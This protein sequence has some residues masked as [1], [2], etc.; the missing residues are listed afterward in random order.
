MNEE[1]S[2]GWHSKD[3][4]RAAALV[5]A[6]Y[7]AV[8]LLWFVNQLII[9]AFMGVLFGLA[10]AAGV[11]R[12]QRYHLR[13]G[14]AAALIVVTFFA[15]LTGLGAWMT[16]TLRSQSAELRVKIPE[17]VDRVEQW[18]SRRQ[19]GILGAVLGGSRSADT[20]GM[21]VPTDSVH[22]GADSTS[23]ANAPKA[24]E[25]LRGS[26]G[27]Q[28]GGASRFLFPFVTHTIAVFGGLM[29]IIFMSIY[30][31]A[32]PDL[33]HRGLMALFP[34]RMRDRAGAVLSAMALVLR[35]WLV[36]QLI[37][38][39]VIGSVTTVA[40]LLLRVKAAFALGVIAGLLE[41]IPT[42]GPIL[43]AIPAVAMGFLDSPEKALTVALLYVGIQFLENHILIP[44]LMK[45]GVDVPPVLTILAQ[46]LF[47]LLFGFIGLM[48]AVPLLAAVMVG[49]KMLYVERVVG[50]QMAVVNTG[51]SG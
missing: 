9:V 21:R 11:D 18:F 42:V 40:L 43:S 24:T 31:A 25:T 3:V 48:V 36:T 45:G 27:R 47:T 49:V 51:E 29:L 34:H 4:A 38:M 41:F 32:D 8:Q 13:R 30:I 5:I 23:G 16:P 6:M 22:D 10:V 19:N 35:R 7:L 14:L 1:R 39:L 46:A 2:V 17:A 26:L 33:Y 37:A 15:V 50:D 20:T 44:L 28:L 12:L